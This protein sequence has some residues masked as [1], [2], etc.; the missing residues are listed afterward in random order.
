MSSR[1]SPKPAGIQPGESFDIDG[2]RIVALPNGATAWHPMN[3]HRRQSL[4]T[5]FPRAKWVHHFDCWFVPGAHAAARIRKWAIEEEAAQRIRDRE[6]R[7]RQEEDE[8][9]RAAPPPTTGAK[10]PSGS[11]SSAR[12]RADGPTA[13]RESLVSASAVAQSTGPAAP[14]ARST[15]RKR[16]ISRPA[17]KRPP[18]SFTREDRP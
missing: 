18:H 11:S 3:F 9:Q 2:I 7:R 14:T 6:R 4:R 10:D 17:G 8:W 1:T 15:Q 13:T 5:T 16:S 12:A